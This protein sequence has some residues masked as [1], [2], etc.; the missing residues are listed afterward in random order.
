MGL[1]SAEEVDDFTEKVDEVTRLI[2]GLQSGALPPEYI[3]KQ[4]GEKDEAA[5][6][7][8]EKA[9]L[10]AEALKDPKV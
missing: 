6:K 4:I 8:K 10:E 1:P 2:K 3:D 9:K 5:K 7:Q